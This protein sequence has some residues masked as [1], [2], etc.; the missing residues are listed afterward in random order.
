[1]ALK[2][3]KSHR[4]I[5]SRRALN[6]EQSQIMDLLTVFFTLLS[7]YAISLIAPG[8]L[9]SLRARLPAPIA[10]TTHRQLDL[11]LANVFANLEI[12]LPAMMID[13]EQSLRP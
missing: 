13:W 7:K 4:V 6:E 10:I 11:S 3:Q 2:K 8:A 9:R 5:N 12:R 1:M